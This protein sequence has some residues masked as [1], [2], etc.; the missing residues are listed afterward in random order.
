[1]LSRFIFDEG[2]EAGLTIDDLDVDRYELASTEKAGSEAGAGGGARTRSGRPRQHDLAGS[3]PDQHPRMWPRGRPGELGA[4]QPPPGLLGP[5]PRS[6]GALLQPEHR[7]VRDQ[8]HRVRR[9][10]LRRA[11]GVRGRP[12]RAHELLR[13]TGVVRT[14]VPRVQHPRLG[15]ASRT[16]RRCCGCATSTTGSTSSP[17]SCPTTPTRTRSRSTGGVKWVIDAYTTTSRATRTPRASAT[18][19]CPTESGLS[20]NDNYVRNSVKAVVDAY[21]G[22][23]TLYVVDEVDP[24]IGRGSRRSP[25]CSRRSRRCPTNCVSICATRRTCSGSRPIAIRS[26]ASR[27]RQ[28]LPSGRCLVGRAGPRPVPGRAHRDR[29]GCHARHGRA[30]RT[31][32]SESNVR[33]FTPYY[34]YLRHERRWVS[35]RTRSS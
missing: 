3:A 16:T 12:R 17:R 11:T 4:R 34:T 20:P 32:A 9:E 8:Q 6:S 24:I 22:E 30:R 28:L 35:R 13:P 27:P 7:R 15:C 29:H 26:T 33:R 5:R 31:F 18:C 2:R 1:M 10:R 23:V 21:T 14:R 25:T 19:S